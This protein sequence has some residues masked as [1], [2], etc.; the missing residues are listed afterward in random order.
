MGP[1][2]TSGILGCQ[3][4]VPSVAHPGGSV[5]FTELLSQT[6]RRDMSHG[7]RSLSGRGLYAAID[8]AGCF[9]LHDGRREV[10]TRVGSF[11]ASED[12]ILV[13]SATGCRVR[14]IGSW[15]EAEG[16]QRA[17]D[18][19]IRIPWD[20]SMPAQATTSITMNGNLRSS[21]DSADATVHRITANLAYTVGSGAAAAGGMTPLADLDQWRGPLGAGATGVLLV[22]GVREDGRVFTEAAIPFAGGTMQ[23]LLDGMTALFDRSTVSLDADGRLVVTGNAAGYSQ[24]MITGMRCGGAGAD[25]LT[26]PTF[27]DYTT[28]GG[29]DRQAFKVTVYDALGEGHVLGGTF[30]KTDTADTWDLVIGSISGEC[31][32]DWRDYDLYRDPALNRRIAGI[33]F[34]SDGSF[35]GPAAPAGSAA[36][37]VRFAG[38]PDSVQTI[39]LD[40]GTPGEFTGLT[41]FAS[42]QSSAAALTQDGYAAG[43]LSNVTIDKTGMIAG[44]FTNGVKAAVAA[45]RIGVFP[46]AGALEAIGGGCFVPSAR[47]GEPTFTTAGTGGAGTIAATRPATASAD[48]A[49]ESVPLSQTRT[50]CQANA[51]TLRVANDILRELTSL[52]R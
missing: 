2:L 7:S 3:G 5:N 42:Q 22:S 8:G 33:R 23:G 10:Y 46:N 31:A 38:N 24:A 21:A 51:R 11:L 16:F 18:A 48:T 37:G 28:I 14:R 30:V 15:G 52:I 43:V 39:E 32:A 40:L 45:L 12:N 44:T 41:Q 20:V 19:D 9:V 50:H 47:S 25:E 26:L 36:F 4:H 27:F 1:A 35:R 29:N 34:D 49:A 17:G 13:D 6:V